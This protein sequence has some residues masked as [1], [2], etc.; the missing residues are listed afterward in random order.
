[1]AELWRHLCHGTLHNVNNII[2]SPNRE[3]LAN[4]IRRQHIY[5]RT[6]QEGSTAPPTPVGFHRQQ[7][8]GRTEGVK[9]ENLNKSQPEKS[10]YK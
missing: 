5:P 7:R 2:G 8:K 6:A 4:G 1:M 3:F 9:E 10:A